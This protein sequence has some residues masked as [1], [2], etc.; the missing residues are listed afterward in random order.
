MSKQK[1]YDMFCVYN[2]KLTVQNTV[3]TAA[4]PY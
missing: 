1:K 4:S 3:F 2:D